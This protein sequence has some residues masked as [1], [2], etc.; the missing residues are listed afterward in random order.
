MSTR[1]QSLGLSPIGLGRPYRNIL[2]LV[3]DKEQMEVL[4]DALK[5]SRKH[6]RKD[7]FGQWTIAGL[8]QPW[9]DLSSYLIYVA[10][11][12]ARR[13]GAIKRKAKALGW[14]V[15][16]DGDD[17]GCFRFGVPNEAEA[18][19]LRGLL[20]LRRH[21]RSDQTIANEGVSAA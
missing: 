19:Y 18:V 6:V 7:T 8:V 3:R 17:E 13:W 5:I 1:N 14:E 11:Y 20:G 16:Q 9:G 21:R 10:A 12:S 2:E 4:A 15:T